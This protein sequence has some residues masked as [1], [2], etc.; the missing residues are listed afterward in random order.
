MLRVGRV[1]VCFRSKITFE[2]FGEMKTDS[3]I[4]LQYL[5]WAHVAPPF[6]FKTYFF[7]PTAN[8]NE[9]SGRESSVFTLTPASSNLYFFWSDFLSLQLTLEISDLWLLKQS[10]TQPCALCLPHTGQAVP[11]CMFISW[12]WGSCHRDFMTCWSSDGRLFRLR[13]QGWGWRW[14]TCPQ[15]S[16]GTCR[17]TPTRTW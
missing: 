15:G 9:F 17:A 7:F 16:P 12:L 2:T 1:C 11:K 10:W 4:L 13:E 8:H 14:E 6:P 3:S 5:F